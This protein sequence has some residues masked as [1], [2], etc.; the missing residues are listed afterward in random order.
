MR[1]P[2]SDNRELIADQAAE[3]LLRLEDGAPS[4]EMRSAFIDWLQES[5][6]HVHEFL[7]IARVWSGLELVDREGNIDLAA[8]ASGLGPGST[9]VALGTESAGAAGSVSSRQRRST[10]VAALASV[11]LTVLA[12]LSVLWLNSATGEASYRT[13]LGEQR[14]IVLSDGS[15]VELNTLTHIS[16]SYEASERRVRLVAGEALFDVETDPNRPFVVDIGDAWVRVLGTRFNI[17]KDHEA[18]A[19]TVIEGRVA[20]ERPAP[21][22]VMAQAGDTQL[23]Q[24]GVVQLTVGDQVRINTAERRMARTTITDTEQVTA[25]TERRLIFDAAPLRDIFRE[26]NRYNVDQLRVEDPSL[27]DLRLSGVFSSNDPDAVI[28]FVRRVRDIEVIERADGT[29]VIRAAQVLE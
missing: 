22:A 28:V 27:A 23:H 26:F 7:A 11:G 6:A 1:S 3:W 21:A 17:Y 10:T 13:V 5:P 8:L 12:I 24:E 29:R 18:T 9:V 15:I 4:H 25:W 14:S 2:H 20:V 19:V 16:V